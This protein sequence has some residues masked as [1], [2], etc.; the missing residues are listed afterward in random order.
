LV[1]SEPVEA[2]WFGVPSSGW[3]WWFMGQSR[4]GDGLMKRFFRKLADL[5]TSK[6]LP[7]TFELSGHSVT[8]RTDGLLCTVDGFPDS[9]FKRGSGGVLFGSPLTIKRGR[10]LSWRAAKAR[11]ELRWGDARWFWQ[12]KRRR[13]LLVRADGTVVATREL[14]R[15]E[16][17]AA[18]GSPDWVV[19]VLTDAGG[20]PADSRP[21]RL[22]GVITGLAELTEIGYFLF[23]I[24][25]GIVAVVTLL[26]SR[27]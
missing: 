24:V 21:I 26:V 25:A 20:V 13:T 5:A 8:V 11:S 17:N 19:A 15:L 4:K 9:W 16:V 23:L 22:G 10:L 27:F 1:C 12:A 14:H 3:R 18:Y 2:G 6:P 7:T